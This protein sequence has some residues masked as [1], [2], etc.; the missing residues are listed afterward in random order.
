MNIAAI[1]PSLNP[2]ERFLAVARELSSAGFSK[3]ILV[4]DGSRPDCR[5]WFDEAERL[6]GCVLLTHT[7]NLGK[8]RALKTAFNYFLQ[9]CPGDIG[10]ITVD[11]DGQHRINDILACAAALENSPGELIL[12]AR[13]FKSAGVPAKSLLGNRITAGVFRY[14]CG[15]AASDTQT[16]LR[17]IPADFIAGLMN[18]AGERFDFETNMLLE[19]RRKGVPIREVSIEAVYINENKS[20]H[21]RPFTD[22]WSIYKLIL[23]FLSVSILSAVIDIG[24]FAL[25]LSA[26][27]FLAARQ[28]ILAATVVSRVLS[29]LF[30]Y[31]ANRGVVFRDGNGRSGSLPRYYALFF[32]QMLCSYG[33]VYLLSRYLHLNEILAKAIIDGILFLFS[34]KIQQIWVFGAAAKGGNRALEK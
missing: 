18:V 33:G 10:V 14:L 25:T 16:G 3:I 9:S 19:T 26:M 24:L 8:G 6:P 2:D 17:G 13:D 21:F 29:S 7:V 27:G 1:I 11:G 4:D 23:A 34:F 5:H 22:S 28:R 15:I 12:G 31:S 20:S 30:N 32:A